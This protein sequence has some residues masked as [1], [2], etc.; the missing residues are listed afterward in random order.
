MSTKSANDSCRGLCAYCEIRN[1]CHAESPALSNLYNV[2]EKLGRLTRGSCLV[3]PGSRQRVS[4]SENEHMFLG[5]VAK[6][7]LHKDGGSHV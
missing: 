1:S 7:F 2:D 3:I 6:V 4:G 5:S